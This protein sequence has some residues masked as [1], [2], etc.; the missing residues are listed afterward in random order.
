MWALRLTLALLGIGCL[1]A[2]AG[3]RWRLQYF[4]DEDTTTLTLHDLSFPSPQRGIAVGVLLEGRRAKPV[5]LL[6]SDGG[7]RWSTVEMP[8]PA[9]SVFFRSENLGWMVTDSGVWRTEEA[10][11]SWKRLA[12]LRGLVR[13]HFVNDQHGWAVGA[14]KAVYETTD[15]GQHWTAVPAAAK[16]KS[17][18]EYTTYQSIDFVGEQFGLIA[19]SSRPPR[20][21][22]QRLPA[23]ME[24]EKARKRR[25]WPGLTILLETRDGGQ[26]W[27]SSESS[28]FGVVTAVRLAPDGRGL[29]V[30]R[31]LEWF[32]WPAEVHLLDRRTGGATRVF[33]RADRD[34]TDVAVVADGAA[35][36]AGIE[37]SGRLPQ[38]PIPGKVKILRSQDWVNWQ[39]MEVDYRAVGRRVVLAGAGPGHLWAATD[40]GMI[41]KLAVE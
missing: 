40:T 29:A 37:P 31:F 36:L 34:I 21:E 25:E 5:A 3:E 7:A 6:T 19:G 11:R 22:R 23:W 41:L 9:R 18:P 27:R 13:V 30:L 28:L 39:E 26:S 4:H 1:C 33:R 16:P 14:P 38:S 15:G 35:Y 32:D 20:R 2:W 8:E 17:T 24:P 12:R 10:G